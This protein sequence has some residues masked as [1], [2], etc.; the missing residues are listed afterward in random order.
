MYSTDRPNTDIFLRVLILVRQYAVHS[1]ALRSKASA[2]R[3]VCGPPQSD[4]IVYQDLASVYRIDLSWAAGQHG[5]QDSIF[6]LRLGVSLCR[7]PPKKTTTTTT[8]LLCIGFVLQSPK[9]CYAFQQ[10]HPVVALRAY[11][12][13]NTQHVM[14]DLDRLAG[15]NAAAAQKEVPSHS[16][17][18]HKIPRIKELKTSAGTRTTHKRRRTRRRLQA[19]F[20]LH[21]VESQHPA[22][23]PHMTKR[24]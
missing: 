12:K 19:I 1:T 4:L 10:S 24:E 7:D 15:P 23:E 9:I 3:V 14:Q 18:P 8:T 16:K 6:S 2:S 21:P 22:Q 13:T 20:K 17:R 11:D 5:L